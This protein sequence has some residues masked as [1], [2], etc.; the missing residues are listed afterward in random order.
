MTQWKKLLTGILTTATVFSMTGAPI[1]AADGAGEST[2]ITELTIQKE[3]YSVIMNENGEKVKNENGV[4][5]SEDFLFDMT[6]D[7]TVKV[8]QDDKGNNVYETDST[9]HLPIKPGIDLG[10]NK[11]IDIAYDST[12][13]N[14][15]QEESFDLSDVTFEGP[16]IY[17]YV[18]EEVEGSNTNIDYDSTKFTVDVMVDADGE[19]AAILDASTNKTFKN[20]IKFENTCLSDYLI[21]DKTVEGKLGD[22]KQQFTFTL[23][24]PEEG[25]GEENGGITLESTTIK[26]LLQ[27][28][29]EKQ[30]L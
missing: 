7:K 24:I 13:E 10:E 30:K 4:L 1:Y 5:P 20:P 17:R 14:A 2:P 16:A 23:D 25:N 27:E 22:K 11:E 9:N 12:T 28:L 21:I 3:F 15:L 8:T 19:I 18:V 29:M 26:V 6:P